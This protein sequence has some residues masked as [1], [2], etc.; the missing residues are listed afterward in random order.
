VDYAEPIVDAQEMKPLDDELP[1]YTRE[2]PFKGAFLSR[3]TRRWSSASRHI[4]VGLVWCIARA[5]SCSPLAQH[6]Q[7][8]LPREV[9][10]SPKCVIFFSHK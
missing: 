4:S 7:P 6:M 10:A 8:T 3:R 1:D 9:S 2:R 5:S